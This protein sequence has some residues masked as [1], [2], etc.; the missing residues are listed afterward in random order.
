MKSGQEA[1]GRRQGSKGCKQYSNRVG[2]FLLVLLALQTVLL[3]GCAGLVT[4]GAKQTTTA[5]FQLSPSSVNFG[6]VL[7]GKQSTQVISVSNIGN[8]GLHL[9]QI[10]F[11]NPQFT[12]PGLSVPMALAAG[13]SGTITVAVNPTAAGTLTGTLTAQGDSGSSPVVVN[14]SATAVSSSPQVSVSPGS[15]DFGSVSVGVKSPTSLLLSNLGSTNLT[16]SMVTLSG[17]E[18]AISGLSTP[19]TIPPGQSVAAAVIFSPT[20]AGSATGSITITCN[21]PVN[22]TVVVPLS[23]T[24]SATPSGVLSASSASLSFGTVAV[25]NPATQQI[26]LTNSGNAEVNVSSITTRGVG[27]SASGIIAPATLNPSQTVTLTVT[28]DPTSAGSTTGSITIVS[29]A[30]NSTFTIPLSGSGAQAGLTI[31]PA[32]YNFGSVVDGQTKSQ[33]FTVTN[34]GAASLSISELSIAGSAYSVSGFSAPMSITPGGSATFNVL[35]APTAAGPLTGTVSISSNAPSSPNT[36]ALSGTGV[37]GALTLSAHPTNVNFTSVNVGSSGSQN[38]TITNAGNTSLTISQVTVEAKDFAVS[39]ISTP[40]TLAVGQSA[41]ITVSFSPKASELVTG[42]ITIM[43]SAG[44]SEALAVF[45]TGV[46]P[47]L[48]I[49]PSSAS[50][51]SVA[52]NSVSTQPIQL[53]NTGTSA[54]TIAQVIVAGTGFSA[55]S[56]S[57][58]LS[59]SSGQSATFSVQFDPTTAGSSTG[60]ISVVSSAPNSPATIALSG[61]GAAATQSLSFGATSV[62][63]GA[64]D[65]GSSSTQTVAITNTGN[66][67]VTVSQI[68]ETGAGF[69]LTGAGTP[70]TLT[71]GQVLVFGVLFAPAT[72]GNASGTVTVTSNA[73]GS[74]ATIALSGVGVAATAHTVTLSWTASTS[75]VSGY[76]I[77]RS[78]TS[79]SGYTLI[80]SGLVAVQTYTD[81][82]VEIGTTYYYVTT[83]VDSS[84]NE[85]TY[86]NQA[87]AVIP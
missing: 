2:P 36:V 60:S 49:T 71:P 17:A 22:P 19:T 1:T 84:G 33:N 61:S 83:A 32:S 12:V 45:G 3:S 5:S 40:L 11:S 41:V 24:G 30:T 87:T 31:A 48:T 79:G 66:T 6:Q 70:V 38:V 37:A 8:V 64:V 28:L 9:T 15:L 44:A 52:V 80:N 42:N 67:S 39:G 74:P 77:Y 62:A 18:F 68:T 72:A 47:A 25:G 58:P 10:Q 34:T 81:T 13:R 50:F 57:L 55:S 21:D 51:G 27:Y 53:T 56:L 63:F 26:T 14:L 20:T 46:L 43:T 75:T 78:T 76:N 82:S 54:L 23:G 7:V 59:L 35:F 16:I 85:S 86:S 4:S 69:S 73:T 65:T 29:T